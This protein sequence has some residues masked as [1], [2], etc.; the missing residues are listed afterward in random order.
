MGVEVVKSNDQ[1]KSIPRLVFY[2]FGQACAL[3]DK[4][5]G[6]I[7][8]VIE[9]IVDTDVNNCVNAFVRMGVLVDGADLDKVRSKVR[10]NFESGLIQVKNKKKR[11]LQTST[12][13]NADLEVEDNNVESTKMSNIGAKKNNIDQNSGVKKEKVDDAEIMSFFTLP[14]EY[15]FVARAISQM[16]GVGKTLDSDFDFISASA[17][18]LVE[19]KG[20]ERYVADEMK[21]RIAPFLNWQVNLQKQL[22]FEPKTIKGAR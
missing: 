4:Q 12:T 19:I 1:S 22:G 21:K 13:N 17:P 9:G 5:A 18:Y 15:A 10:Q 7:L 20:S 2:D 6:G 11:K 8:D 14:A 3:K 16:D